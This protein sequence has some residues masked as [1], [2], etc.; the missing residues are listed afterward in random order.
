MRAISLQPILYKQKPNLQAASA[1][2]ESFLGTNQIKSRDVLK[3]S[4]IKWLGTYDNGYPNPPSR[5]DLSKWRIF[6]ENTA[7]LLEAD[8]LFPLFDL[9]RMILL[10]PRI[11]LELSQGTQPFETFLDKARSSLES[12]SAES[13]SPRNTLV[14]LL[15]LLS[16]A[17]TSP[18]LSGVLLLRHLRQSVMAVVVPCLLH[19]D[20]A[21]RTA[22]AGVA[23]NAATR[24]QAARVSHY[25]DGKPGDTV[26]ETLGDEDWEMEL[27]T[28]LLEALSQETES[29]EVGEWICDYSFKSM[30]TY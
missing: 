26:P 20:S 1:K 4:L 28:A 12:P 2:L 21:V 18:E 3:S 6:S 29:E 25:R 8:K 10:D 7:Q 24:Y 23:F 27:T 13:R 11:G 19:A 16:N 9:W 14:T 5:L 17:F 15:R 30:L 22:A